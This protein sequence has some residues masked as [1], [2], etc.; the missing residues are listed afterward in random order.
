MAVQQC[1]C[2]PVCDLGGSPVPGGIARGRPA[3]PL[4]RASGRPLP[5]PIRPHCGSCGGL[6]QSRERRTKLPMRSHL[7]FDDDLHGVTRQP[8]GAA[9]RGE[10]RAPDG[11]VAA[12]GP[13]GNRQGTAKSGLDERRGACCGLLQSRPNPRGGS[14]LSSSVRSSAHISSSLRA[15]ADSV[16][17]SGRLSSHA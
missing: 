10:D 12:Q 3:G 15:V 11:T 5:E 9:I 14:T 2:G 6:R 17:L 7:S 13:P 8:G 1:R 4:H 16:R